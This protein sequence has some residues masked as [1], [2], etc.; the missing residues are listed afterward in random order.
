M[1]TFTTTVSFYNEN[2]EDILS[3]FKEVYDGLN[4]I[5][6]IIED[7]HISGL[8]TIDIEPT[9]EFSI[10]NRI[11]NILEEHDLKGECW[12]LKDT[13]GFVIATEEYAELI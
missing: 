2:V 13:N 10:F 11:S 5:A 6:E 9:K 4:P 12:T 1:Y 8:I 3:A 7:S